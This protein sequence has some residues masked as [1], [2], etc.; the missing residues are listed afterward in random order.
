MILWKSEIK[1]Q[2]RDAASDIASGSLEVHWKWKVQLS[3]T[4]M[5]LN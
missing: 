2:E 5:L 4:L 3:A 1:S